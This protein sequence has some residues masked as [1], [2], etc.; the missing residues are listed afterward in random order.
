MTAGAL[1]WLIVFGV[2]AILFFAVAL[3]VTFR[4]LG[5]LRELLGKKS[6]EP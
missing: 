4:G 5:D 2:S 6:P 1:F 3:V